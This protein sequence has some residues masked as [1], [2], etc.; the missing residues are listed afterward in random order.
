LRLALVSCPVALFPTVHDRAN[1][2]FHLINPKTGHR[3][4]MIT[5]DSETGDE[6]SR[7]ELVKGYEFK[8]DH[9]LL[10]EDEDFQNARI[11]SSTV[12]SIEKFV[13]TSSIDPIYFDASYFLAPDGDAG[14]DVFVV[15]R[16]AIA[17]SGMTALSRVVMAQRER[18]VALGVLGRGLVAYTLHDARDLNDATALFDDLPTAKA[19]PEMIKLASQLIDRQ[20]GEYDPSDWEDRYENR[21]RAVI[22]ARLKGEGIEPE[23]D[24]TSRDNVIDLMAALKQSLAGARPAPA[25]RKAPAKAS[26]SKRVAGKRK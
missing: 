11:E 15:L 9:Y 1:L 7:G 14:Q 23:P 16:E 26:S 10:M 25:V 5:R 19:D 24:D 13:P 6:V 17:K 12:L 18:V 8:K 4:R 21:L 20:V 22:E 2:H 3:V